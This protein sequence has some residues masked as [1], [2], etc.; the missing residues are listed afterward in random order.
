MGEDLRISHDVTIPAA[1]LQESFIRAPGPGGQHVNKSSTAVQLRFDAAA[2]AA[3]SDDVKQRLLSLAGARASEAGVIIIDASQHRSQRRNRE[4][5]RRR[6]AELIARALHRP[7]RRKKT[8]PTA[9]SKQRRLE[10]KRRSGQ[11][12]DLRRSIER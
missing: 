1:Q 4:D 3:L 10:T 11:K 8:R 6:L 2:C 7:K 5:A 12:K 9:A